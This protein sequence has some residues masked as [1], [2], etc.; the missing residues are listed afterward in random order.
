MMVIAGA[1]ETDM[2]VPIFAKVDDTIQAMVKTFMVRH[3]SSILTF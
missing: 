3:R 2:I 1:I